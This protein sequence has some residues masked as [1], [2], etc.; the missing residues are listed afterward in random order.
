MITRVKRWGIL[1]KPLI[2]FKI[3]LPEFHWHKNIGSSAVGASFGIDFVNKLHL[4]ISKLK[5]TRIIL[6]WMYS[7]KLCQ[8]LICVVDDKQLE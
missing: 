1:D 4:R 2:E 5:L 6:L 8:D 7:Y 3:E